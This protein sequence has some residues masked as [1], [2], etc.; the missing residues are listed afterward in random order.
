MGGGERGIDNPKI[1][2]FQGQYMKE[3]KLLENLINEFKC[4]IPLKNTK[5]NIALKFIFY[6]VTEFWKRTKIAV[7]IN[8]G[9]HYL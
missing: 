8:A 4:K 9:S 7:Y 1:K 3:R 5:F 6:K 2:T